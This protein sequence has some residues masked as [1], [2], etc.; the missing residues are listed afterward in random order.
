VAVGC[1]EFAV[2]LQY[3]NVNLHIKNKFI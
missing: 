3:K 1:G 2:V